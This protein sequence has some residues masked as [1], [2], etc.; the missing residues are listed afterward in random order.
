VTIPKAVRGL[1]GLDTDSMMA[2]TRGDALHGR[3]QTRHAGTGICRV[4]LSPSSLL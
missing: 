4:T 1:L 3:Y 2:R